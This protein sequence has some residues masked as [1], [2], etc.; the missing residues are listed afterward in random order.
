VL[1]SIGSRIRLG[2]GEISST[3]FAQTLTEAGIP[4]EC[5]I[6]QSWLAS[7]VNPPLTP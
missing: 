2:G 7:D 5:A 1:T 6:G 3:A 4:L